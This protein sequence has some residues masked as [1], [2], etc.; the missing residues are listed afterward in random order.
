MTFTF[1]AALPQYC[2]GADGVGLYAAGAVQVDVGFG[3]QDEVYREDDQVVGATDAETQEDDE[4][5]GGG[6]FPQS[7]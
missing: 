1:E 7:A 2:N 6:G 4:A 3:Y 5:G